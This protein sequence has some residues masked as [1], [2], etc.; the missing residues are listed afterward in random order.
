[1]AR[2]DG[3]IEPGQKLAGAISARAWNRAQDAADRV[4]G[5]GT[6]FGA[7]AGPASHSALYC[8]SAL[9][10]QFSPV[11]IPR[12]GMIVDSSEGSIN[13]GTPVPN[14]GRSNQRE[15]PWRT[16]GEDI[17]KLFL[18]VPF[19]ERRKTVLSRF[20]VIYDGT[21]NKGEFATSRVRLLT[22]GTC[23]AMV[24]K[25]PGGYLPRVRPAVI[26]Y[27]TDTGFNLR[28]IAEDSDCGFGQLVRWTN[29]KPFSSQRQNS[30]GI[31]E[32]ESLDDTLTNVYYAV[33][34]I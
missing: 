22:H 21:L 33:I 15:P 5:V 6:G 28:G 30:E 16:Q 13:P 24:R 10:N 4:L 8:D 25:N 19:I 27:A 9:L 32:P 29:I 11:R 1:M 31:E 14:D 23:I 18:P 2:N 20:S 3:R 26:R 7:G 17:C 12:F 34:R